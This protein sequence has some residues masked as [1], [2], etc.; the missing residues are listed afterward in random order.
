[1][2]NNS[3]SAYGCMNSSAANYNPSATI[4][5]GSCIFGATFVTLNMNDS[6]GDGWN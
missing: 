4:D 5:D 2:I 1:M 6:Y 3:N